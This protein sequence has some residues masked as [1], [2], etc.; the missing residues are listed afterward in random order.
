MQLLY[1]LFYTGNH[2][3]LLLS[4]EPIMFCLMN[5]LLDYP[6][7]TSTLQVLY[8]F[9]N[10]LKVIFIIQTSSTRLHVIVILHPIHLGIQTLSHMKLSY[11]PMEIKLVLIYWMKKILQSHTSLI[12][13]Q[14]HHP[15]IN[16]HHKLREICGP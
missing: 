7:K 5:I 4:T 15:V 12:Q 2:I 10:I 11:L 14:V 13:Y 6:Y 9:G 8:Y 1:E 16:F 3:K